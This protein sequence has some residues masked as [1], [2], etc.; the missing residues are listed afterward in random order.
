MIR[1]II[2][3]FFLAFAFCLINGQPVWAQCAMC[4]TTV[5]NNVSQGDVS[6]AAG[7]NVG[8]LYL[9]AA[10]YLIVAVLAYLWYRQ[11]KKNAA[12]VKTTRYSQS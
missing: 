11:S 4:R 12:R 7:L 8:I 2:T 10:P 3:V 6:L 5:E 9:F 1:K